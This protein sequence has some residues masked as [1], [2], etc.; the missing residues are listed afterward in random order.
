M[1]ADP[2]ASRKNGGRLERFSA[3]EARLD[4]EADRQGRERLDRCAPEHQRRARG[5]QAR[6]R[7][8]H[9]PAVRGTGRVEPGDLCLGVGETEVSG[10]DQ[11]DDGRDRGQPREV[12]RPLRDEMEERRRRLVVA[13]VA[14]DRDHRERHGRLHPVD[15]ERPRDLPD[16]ALDRPGLGAV[17]QHPHGDPHREAQDPDRLGGRPGDVRGGMIDDRSLLHRLVRDHSAARGP[18]GCVSR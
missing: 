11:A 15:A 13:R 5:G 16:G 14:R 4:R 10:V 2:I 9:C 3:D 8:P 1:P 6:R 18:I 17:G 12:G 7:E